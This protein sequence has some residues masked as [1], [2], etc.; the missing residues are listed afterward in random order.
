MREV[1]RLVSTRLKLVEL[2]EICIGL[3]ISSDGRKKDLLKRINDK[4]NSGDESNITDIGELN[5]EDLDRIS[6]PNFRTFREEQ[7]R[8]YEEGLKQDK[9]RG[10]ERL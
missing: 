9:I 5:S 8:E 10:L 1:R 4:I 7:E 2:Q 3:G 6:D